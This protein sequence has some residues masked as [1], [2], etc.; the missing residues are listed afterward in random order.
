[1]FRKFHSRAPNDGNGIK[2]SHSP[3]RGRTSAK[4][5]Q[6]KFA[7]APANGSSGAKLPFMTTPANGR[8]GKGFRMPARRDLSGGAEGRRPKASQE[9]TRGGWAGGLPSMGI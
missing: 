8:V 2:A 9:G 7:V 3:G 4:G 6:A 5:R 1:V